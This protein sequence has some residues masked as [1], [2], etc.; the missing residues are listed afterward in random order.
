MEIESHGCYGTMEV[1]KEIFKTLIE[2][3]LKI[4]NIY[5]FIN[6]NNWL[7]MYIDIQ[8]RKNNKCYTSVFGY[9]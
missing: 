1:E 4:K 2:K 3:K 8:E 5:I 9:I 6:G 7:L